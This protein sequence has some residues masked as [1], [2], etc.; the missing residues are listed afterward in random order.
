MLYHFKI[1]KEEKYWWA[2]C[3]ELPGCV[4]QAK[5]LNKLQKN[6]EEALNLYLDEPA[7]SHLHFPLP[8]HSLTGEDIVLVRVDPKVAFSTVLKY[9]RY[10]HHLTQKQTAE[11]LGLKSVYSYQRLEK[12]SNPSL[13]TLKKL[14]H[15]FPD[16]SVD[17][18]LS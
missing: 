9:Y 14:K 6:M 13:Q 2:E 17:Y 15:V 3:L 18:I 1:Y 10:I 11:K 8:D 5:S 7:T 4:T 16:F 12:K